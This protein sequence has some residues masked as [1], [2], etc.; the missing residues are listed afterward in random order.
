MFFEDQLHCQ[1]LKALADETRFRLIRLLSREELNVQELCEVLELPQP[2]ISRHL[3]TLKGAGLVSDRR[4]GT[5]VFYS[6]AH[7]EEHLS[8]LAG[9][10]Q[11]IAESE[12]PDLEKLAI[13]LAKR[14]QAPNETAWAEA[15]KQ[16]YQPSSA[17]AAIAQLAPRQLTVADLG[18]GGGMM[19]PYL[20][21][22]A[23]TVYAVDHSREMLKSAEQASRD[24][25]LKNIRF[26]H[27]KLE[28]VDLHLPPCD[29]LLLH[30]VI[31]Q[32][33]NL[34]SLF[35]AIQRVLKP[36]G[37]VVIV[38]RTKHQDE[39]ARKQ[40]GS[41]WLGFEKSQIS[42]ILTASG[43]LLT[44]WQETDAPETDSRTFICSATRI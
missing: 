1:I 27:T 19:L 2:S 40:F 42:Q 17:M 34:T 22:F 31:H 10:L 30:F 32:I 16:L 29:A 23:E 25:Q 3:S 33:P 6:L 35:A 24:S 39:S 9:Y 13:C 4:Q 41:H 20:S 11:Q 18:T 28:E 37:R 26:V 7:I 43:L 21:Q 5:K 8:S 12:H 44:N 15:V 36:N 14:R 38:D